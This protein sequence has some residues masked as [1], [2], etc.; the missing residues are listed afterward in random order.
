M[1]D[2]TLISAYLIRCSGESVA[3]MASQSVS[4]LVAFAGKCSSSNFLC[5]GKN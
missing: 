5:G 3:M 2:R 4:I 1:T